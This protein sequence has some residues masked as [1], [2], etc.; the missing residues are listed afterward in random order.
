MKSVTLFLLFSF[1][2]FSGELTINDP[3][4]KLV[5]KALLE[6]TVFKVDVYNASYFKKR[7]E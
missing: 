6:V 1:P 4:W 3:S 5:G 2:L 7:E